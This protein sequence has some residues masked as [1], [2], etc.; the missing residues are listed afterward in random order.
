MSCYNPP[1]AI[2]IRNFLR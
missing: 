1:L 2:S